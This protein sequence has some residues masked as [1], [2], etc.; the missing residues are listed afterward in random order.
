MVVE[1]ATMEDAI[2]NGID[3]SSNAFMLIH[4]WTA[5]PLLLEFVAKFK[6]LLLKQAMTLEQLA[7]E[8]GAEQGPLAIVL[9][10]CSI[11]GYL[12][13]DPETGMY[14]LVTGLELDELDTYLKPSAPTAAAI[15][16]LYSDVTPPFEF[17][18]EGAT[19]C[20]SVWEEH[21]PTWKN[22]KSK[23]LSILLDGIVLA[24]LLTSITYFARW[25]EDGQEYAKE[26]AMDRFDF[27]K[28][29]TEE[30]EVL[31]DIIEEL[32]VGTMSAKGLVATSSK[33]SL[34]LQRC[35]SFYVPVSYAPMLAHFPDILYE[36]PGWGFVDTGQDTMETEEHVDRTL[37]VIGSGAQH[38]TLFKDLM[39]HI[40]LVFSGE[41]FASQP[42]FVVD[43]GCGDGSLLMHVYDHVKHNMPR[44]KALAEHPLT[45]VGVDFNEDSR[46][47]TAVNLSKHGSPHLVVFGD[48]GKPSDIMKILRKKKVDLSK[49]LHVRSFLDHDR[50][51]IAPVKKLAEGTV[52]AR[53][54]RMQMADFV[55]LDKEGSP[56]TALEVFA[57]LVEHFQRWADQL[58]GTFGLCLLEVMMLDVPTTQRF[59][60]D[61]VSF[62]FDIV[63]CL[64]RQYMIS[65]AAFAMGGAM[66]GLLPA[67]FQNVTTYPEDGKYCR[68]IN[69]HLK[70]RP[71]KV[72]FAEV[73]DLPR[74][75]ELE[76]L[77]WDDNLRAKPNVL[78][79]RLET[80][81]T[82]N[83]VCE[84]N[85]KVVAVLYMQLIESVDL[86]DNERFMEIS[87]AHSPTGRIVQLIAISSDP[88]EKHLGLGNELKAFALHLA[89]L[90]QNVESV[91]GVTRCQEFAHF[92]GS[93]QAYV[94]EHVA[95]D[96][97]DPTLEFHTGAGARVIR[98]VRDFRPEDTANN[99]T[100][101]LIQYDVKRVEK[102]QHIGGAVQQPSATVPTLD[103]LSA[104][105]T[106]L[107]YPPDMDDLSKGFFDYGMDSLELV[108]IRNKLSSTLDMDLAATLLLDFPTVQD[109]AAHMDKE[110]G[111]G[112]EAKEE[113]AQVAAEPKHAGWDTIEARDL[114][115]MQ[116]RCKQAYA[117]NTYQQRFKDIAKKCYPDML[118]Y[119]LAIEH[120]LLEVEGPIFAD[121]GLLPTMDSSSVQK[122]REEMT[123]HVAKFWRDSPE[124]RSKADDLAHLTR[125]DQMW[126]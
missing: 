46:M 51:Y 119:M 6:P 39:R 107:G 53:Y 76:E 19:A 49:T 61:C 68:I 36:D 32:G 52:T 81:P 112:I 85:G 96:R 29:P 63:Q 23:G 89:R 90:D 13:F 126:E 31:G 59:L 10:T 115:D 65:P 108:R 121:Y 97:C 12:D 48:I 79:L 84:M 74:L 125:Q 43:T 117:Q 16:G 118:R 24:P 15:G 109:L 18:S 47:Q 67:N 20:L 103:L 58:E 98:L 62:H 3:L 102:K 30:R 110:R 72:R 21:R 11:L 2:P 41:D 37:N 56:I 120:I 50:P 106:D 114:L 87:A 38:K 45:L 28:L 105:M 8:A 40:D 69:Q 1:H 104:I 116:E 22:S 4:G 5:G 70:R 35:Y 113:E 75:V 91:I 60:N 122:C 100:G 93:M 71:F 7:S 64:S 78:K 111:V 82:T 33:G 44:G 77:A 95:G 123:T 26:G 92:S 124:I 86:V 88:E 54:A 66:A 94:D 99:G 73:S 42:Q 83:L 14:S 27:G 101:V 57:S 9:R 34:A 25:N 17:P 55:H 80:S